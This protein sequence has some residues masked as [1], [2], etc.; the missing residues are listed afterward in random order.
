VTILGSN[1]DTVASEISFDC[2]DLEMQP[3]LDPSE[4]LCYV[5]LGVFILYFYGLI[6]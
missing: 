6:A 5:L 2:T 3:K 4:P 1:I